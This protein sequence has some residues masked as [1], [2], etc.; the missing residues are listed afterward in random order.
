MTQRHQI[1]SASFLRL[2][3]FIS[4]VFINNLSQGQFQGGG[5]VAFSHIVLAQKNSE[6]L[7]KGYLRGKYLRFRSNIKVYIESLKLGRVPQ[8]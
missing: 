1:Q 4:K 8:C 5:F 3:A 6:K 2:M 7:Y